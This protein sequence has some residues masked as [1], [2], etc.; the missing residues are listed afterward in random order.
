MQKP[1]IKHNPAFLTDEELAATF[2]VRHD[3]LNLIARVVRENTTA[4]NQ[5]VLV[6]GPRGIGKTMLVRRVAIEVRQDE[7]LRQKWYPL[8]FAEESY[9]VGTA[10]EF[11]L[12]SL[13]HLGRQTG[14]P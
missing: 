10:G 9:E 1:P 11:W 5:H 14:D 4:S 6:I 12:E 3:D 2:V 13:F 8:I 7:E